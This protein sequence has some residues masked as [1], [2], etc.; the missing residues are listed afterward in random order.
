MTAPLR[1][2][3]VDLADE[4][5]L[6]Q[7]LAVSF[8]E[9][10]VNGVLSNVK[11]DIETLY[12]RTQV[13][14]ISVDANWPIRTVPCNGGYERNEGGT[15]KDLFGEL[16][17][18][19]ELHPLGARGRKRQVEVAGIAS[20]VARLKV[21]HQGH[22]VAIASWRME[23]GD[24]NS[25]GAFFHAQIPDSL[26]GSGQPANSACPQMWPPWLPVPRLPIPPMTPMLALEFM[27]AEIFRDSWLQHLESGGYEV[28]R[29]RTLQQE[30]F[31]RYFEWQRKNAEVSGE[32]SPILAIRDAKPDPE[33][34]L[35]P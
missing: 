2:R 32:G 35:S 33:L 18:K 14:S 5:E 25:P 27:L 6:M 28:D 12:H 34:L 16:L 4:V 21:D 3:V 9:P 26:G 1:F 22:E 10:G 11:D 24:L 7:K 31:E 19:W 13:I 29:W 20:S 30:R 15:R 23:V 17:F 8:L